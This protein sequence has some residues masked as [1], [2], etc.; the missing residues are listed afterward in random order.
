MIKTSLS[1]TLTST[2]LSLVLAAPGLAC[3]GPK[4]D[5]IAAV[6]KFLAAKTYHASMSMGPGPA[7]QT[8]FVAPDRMRVSMGAMGEQ[9]MIGDTLYLT[10]R[11]KTSKQ[12][13]PGGGIAATRSRD[14]ILGNPQTLKV[15]ALG[16]ETL[17]GAT[18]R[19]YK[20]ENTQPKS[21]STFWVGADGYPVQAVNVAEVSG[22]QYTSTLKYSRYNDPSIKIQAPA[23]K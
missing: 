7:T 9:V 16:A 5:V 15:T 13:A 8:D 17:A 12:A 21:S 4:E 22:K 3:A 23:V 1:A 19:K 10:L 6:D 11:G 20:V 14:K 18:T 2:V